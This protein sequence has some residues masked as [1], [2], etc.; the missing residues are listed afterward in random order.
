MQRAGEAKKM[1]VVVTVVCAVV[2]WE[3]EQTGEAAALEVKAKRA[4]AE[5][6]QVDWEAVVEAVTDLGSVVVEMV[7][8]G[9]RGKAAIL[10][11]LMVGGTV[12]TLEG[13]AVA[14]VA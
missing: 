12:A 2:C 9:Q 4:E 7:G 6:A 3:E 13:T 1:A 5:T 14:E 8:A 10:V 11:A